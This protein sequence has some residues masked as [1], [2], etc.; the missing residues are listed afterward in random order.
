MISFA[1]KTVFEILW[2]ALGKHNFYFM[3]E[4]LG[5]S[6]VIRCVRVGAWQSCQTDVRF[7]DQVC[8][9]DISNT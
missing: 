9:A 3:K 8:M 6:K 1:P 4:L 2:E 7:L 5:E